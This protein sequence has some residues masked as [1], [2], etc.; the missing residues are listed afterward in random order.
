[1]PTRQAS[2]I[3]VKKRMEL[4]ILEADANLSVG[5]VWANHSDSAKRVMLGG[6]NELKDFVV[7]WDENITFLE[8]SCI[9]HMYIK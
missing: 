8:L 7:S 3:L 4:D 1:M 9:I 2:I 5:A 6:L